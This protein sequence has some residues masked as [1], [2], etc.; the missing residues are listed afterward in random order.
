MAAC[1]GWPQDSGLRTYLGRSHYEWAPSLGNWAL[2]GVSVF[3]QAL[4]LLF[5]IKIIQSL[6]LQLSTG[7]LHLPPRLITK[8]VRRTCGHS[9]FLQASPTHLRSPWGT[10]F[11]GK[12]TLMVSP[13]QRTFFWLYKSWLWGVARLQEGS[14][15]SQRILGA[16]WIL[17]A[18]AIK[19]SAS[20]LP[21]TNWCEA[22]LMIS[23]YRLSYVFAT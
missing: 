11:H 18:L 13:C 23:V 2:W 16:C 10:D 20:C 8:N 15:Q 4:L 5:T 14:E 17:P 6:H 22:S 7:K 12:R 19:Q 3:R 9:L 21:Y 1:W